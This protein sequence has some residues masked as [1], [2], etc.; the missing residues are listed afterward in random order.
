MEASEVEIY[1][2]VGAMA[3]RLMLHQPGVRIHP[4]TL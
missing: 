2:R 3:Q 1:G 4:S